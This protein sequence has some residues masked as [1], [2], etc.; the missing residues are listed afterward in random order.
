MPGTGGIPGG[1]CTDEAAAAGAALNG[2]RLAW[3]LDRLLR[4]FSPSTGAWRCVL[5]RGLD[6]DGVLRRTCHRWLWNRQGLAATGARERLAERL[7]GDVQHFPAMWAVH[8]ECHRVSPRARSSAM[9]HE[10][11]AVL[12]AILISRNR[13][14]GL[15]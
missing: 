15:R 14:D 3:S 8:L 6:S 5:R 13:T 2:H 10:R 9:Y 1:R 4:Y 11:E 12:I 7:F